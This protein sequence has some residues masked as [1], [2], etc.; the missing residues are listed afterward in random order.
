MKNILSILTIVLVSLCS[1]CC[2]SSLKEL[3]ASHVST[4]FSNKIIKPISWSI[5]RSSFISS[6]SIE[7]LPFGGDDASQDTKDRPKG[8]FFPIFEKNAVALME[9]LFGNESADLPLG[10]ASY[11]LKIKVGKIESKVALLAWQ[12]AQNTITLEFTLLEFKEGK[13]RVVTT[14]EVSSTAVG[15]QGTGCNFHDK[16]HERANRA[17]NEAFVKARNQFAASLNNYFSKS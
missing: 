16:A 2:T 15:P 1:G 14:F 6:Q 4:S 17:I 3:N 5:D 11:I 7:V 12:E 8:D 9:S 13:E 10:Q